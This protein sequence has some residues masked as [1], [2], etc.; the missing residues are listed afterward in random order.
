MPSD[1]VKSI[2]SIILLVVGA[3]S[4]PISGGTSATVIIGGLFAIWGINWSGGE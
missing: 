4:L 1:F 3:P 2:L